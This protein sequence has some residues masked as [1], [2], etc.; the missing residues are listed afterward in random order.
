MN[1][2]LLNAGWSVIR[3]GSLAWACQARVA[4]S[5]LKSDE[6][7]INRQTHDESSTLGRFDP[8]I[9]TVIEQSL[10]GQRKPQSQAVVLARGNERL[11]QPVADPT[12]NSRSGVLYVDQ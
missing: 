1:C 12:R 2:E 7:L 3:S 4:M 5:D 8:Y 9:A 11:E 6:R 10:A